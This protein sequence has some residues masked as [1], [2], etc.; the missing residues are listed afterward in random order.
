MQR[1]LGRVCRDP[2][3]RCERIAATQHGVIARDQALGAGMTIRSIE[4]LVTKHRWKAPISGVY[5]PAWVPPSRDQ[6]LM[7]AHLWA[8]A[9]SCVSHRAAGFKWELD[10][11]EWDAPEVTT[12]K[13]MRHPSVIAHYCGR[14]ACDHVTTK[15][16]FVITNPTRTIVDLAACLKPV[17]FEA[18]LDSALR[19]RLT[20]MELLEE[21][22]EGFGRGRRG[23]ASCARSWP[24]AEPAFAWSRAISRSISIRSCAQQDCPLPRASIRLCTVGEWWRG[25]ILRG[26]RSRSAS[27][28]TAGDGTPRSRRGRR[29]PIGLPCW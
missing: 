17:P 11:V 15:D 29:I 13:R 8:G 21:M 26:R 27:R 22:L 24:T 14:L 16:G 23:V 7:M 12:P 18:A 2:I 3:S 19:R 1:P 9:G 10:G 6:E 25:S 4:H 20:H 28:D 5:V